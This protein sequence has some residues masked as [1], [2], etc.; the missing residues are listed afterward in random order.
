M[1]EPL[2]I[3]VPEKILLLYLIEVPEPQPVDYISKNLQ[4]EKVDAMVLP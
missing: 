3:S 2:L 1:E 4:R